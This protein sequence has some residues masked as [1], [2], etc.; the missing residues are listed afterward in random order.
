[1]T[2]DHL[3]HL[4]IAHGHITESLR[5]LNRAL[6]LLDVEPVGAGEEPS[7]GGVKPTLF[8]QL[9]TTTHRGHETANQTTFRANVLFI[10][11]C[12]AGAH[13]AWQ[14]PQFRMAEQLRASAREALDA[15][16]A[17]APIDPGTAKKREIAKTHARVVL[18]GFGRR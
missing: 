1:M 6:D 11:H 15:I 7:A 16:E 18:E 9:S 3:D 2:R 12:I 14:C 10:K 17:Q 8:D 4:C 13:D 5:C